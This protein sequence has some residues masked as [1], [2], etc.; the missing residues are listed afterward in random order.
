VLAALPGLPEFKQLGRLSFKA[1][2]ERVQVCLV[3]PRQLSVGQL[4]LQ[5]LSLLNPNLD[6]APANAKVTRGLDWI[7][8]IFGCIALHSREPTMQLRA[9]KRKVRGHTQV[10][11]V[12]GKLNI[13]VGN[14]PVFNQV[15]AFLI[16]DTAHFTI[17][18]HE[19]GIS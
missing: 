10:V 4:V 5:K 19:H 18:E 13:E 6:R 17:R 15:P 2:Y 8:P 14:V 1:L 7:E 11:A 16:L 9:R 12:H 3:I